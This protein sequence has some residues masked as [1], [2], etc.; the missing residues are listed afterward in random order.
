MSMISL[1]RIPCPRRVRLTA[2]VAPLLIAQGLMPGLGI[3]A[4]RAQEI[5]PALPPRTGLKPPRLAALP[6]LPPPLGTPQLQSQISCPALQQ[7][8]AAVVSPEWDVWSVTVAD[9][10]GRLLADVNGTT[11]RLPASNQKLIST[12]FALDRLGPDHRL[13]TQL[14]RLPDGRLRLVGQGDPDLAVPQLQRFARLAIASSG[15]SSAT[16][17]RLE[18]AEEA[19]DAWWPRGWN[20]GDR[21][22]AY[23]APVTRL[24]VTSNAQIGRAHV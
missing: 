23:G 17:V 24:A 21:T 6:P 11:P 22:T 18:L 9:A 3:A 5:T 7:R 4:A 10:R 1:V 20:W 14:W 15:A 2:W 16:P 8:V 12:A 13:S 19:P